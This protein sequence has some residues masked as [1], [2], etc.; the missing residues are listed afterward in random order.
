MT[1]LSSPLGAIHRA[2]ALTYG[3]LVASLAA[4]LAALDG[5]PGDAGA[6]LALSVLC[7][8][9]DGRFARLFTRTPAERQAGAQ[10]DSLSDAIAFGA[11][12]I[13]CVWSLG[14]PSLL[15]ASAYAAGIITRLAFFNVTHEERAGFV[16][17]PAPVAALILATALLLDP[18]GRLTTPLLVATAAATVLPIPIPRPRGAGLAAFVCWPLAV[19]TLH[20]L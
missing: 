16:G 10:L 8:T 2:N 4:M 6:L 15:A 12:P 11:A 9:F 13:V 5:R 18:S 20:V 3:S 14:E 1:G 7:D 19:L 17:V